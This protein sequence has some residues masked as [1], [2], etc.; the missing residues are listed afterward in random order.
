MKTLLLSIFIL[1]ISSAFGQISFK[2][3]D[4]GLD[5]E[6]NVANDEAKK[7][8]SLFKTN[9]SADFNISIPKIEQLLKMM[10]PGEILIAAKISSIAS[11]PIDNVV[12]S[13]QKNK[14]KG[15]GVIAKEMGIKPGSP[16]FHA[17][18]GK[19]KGKTPGNSPNKDK[20]NSG[21]KGKS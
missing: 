15:W 10:L 12:E 16:E 20:G 13:Y 18:K 11:Q 8:L 14:E 4:S 19:G 9:L 3:G 6:L 17:L 21:G 5:A 7:D 1:G 2:T